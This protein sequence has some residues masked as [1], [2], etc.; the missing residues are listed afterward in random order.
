MDNTARPARRWYRFSMGTLLALV[1][2]A[3]V[4]FGAWKIWSYVP[5]TDRIAAYEK[6][7]GT[8]QS[9]FDVGPNRVRL[10]TIARND[11]DGTLRV[12]DGDRRAE[13][14]RH[15]SDTT[16]IA[17]AGSWLDVAEIRLAQARNKSI[18]STSAFSTPKP[19]R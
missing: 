13:A 15:V 6:A 1:T 4:V 10:A 9:Y 5:P 14:K 19:E 16:T 17:N 3:A 8:R 11:R 18:L 2:L 12:E 7:K